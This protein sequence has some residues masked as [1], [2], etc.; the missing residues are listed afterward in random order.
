MINKNS[1]IRNTKTRLPKPYN[2]LGVMIEKPFA[3]RAS[4]R[5]GAIYLVRIAGLGA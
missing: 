5:P 4:A 3:L 1:K 2:W